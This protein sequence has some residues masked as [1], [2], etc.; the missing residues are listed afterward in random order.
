M[1]SLQ[2]RTA[3]RGVLTPNFAATLGAIGPWV[4]L[5]FMLLCAFLPPTPWR[6]AVLVGTVILLV[7]TKCLRPLAFLF[8]QSRAGATLLDLGHQHKTSVW[9]IALSAFLGLA[10]MILFSPD[11][12]VAVVRLGV[13]LYFLIGALANLAMNFQPTIVAEKGFYSPRTIAWWD[14]IA[15][16]QW[17]NQHEDALL[18]LMLKIG[19]GRLMKQP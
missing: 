17:L 16:R 5:L 1:S 10:W 19:A 9:Q 4:L 2:D 18:I 15:A 12:L 7:I 13:G 14:D 6:D 3:N 8:A 11:P